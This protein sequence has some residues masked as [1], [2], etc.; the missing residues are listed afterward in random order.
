MEKYDIKLPA[1]IDKA[2]NINEL[3]NSAIPKTFS[4]KKL[5]DN[6]TNRNVKFEKPKIE[7]K[8]VEINFVLSSS[9]S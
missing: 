1:G 9:V 8:P 2:I 5:V 4:I 3:L 7:K 6:R